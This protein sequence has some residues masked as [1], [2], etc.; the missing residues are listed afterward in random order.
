M[1][2]S[3]KIASLPN[4][5]TLLDDAGG[6]FL[7]Q[8][9]AATTTSYT[10]T[11][12]GAVGG[13]GALLG[14]TNSAGA[15]GWLTAL[16]GLTI[17]N[18]VI[19]GSTPAAITGTTVTATSSFVGDI[20]GDVTGNADTATTLATPRTFSITGDGTSTFAA[21]NGS[22]NVSGALTLATVNSNVGSFGSTTAIPVVTVNAKGLVTAVSTASVSSV[23]TVA[24]DS[25]SND[26]VTLGTDTLTF[27]GTANEIETTVSDNQIQIGLPATILTT[28]QSAGDNSTKVATT[29]YVDTATAALVDSAPSTLDTLNE[30]AA[31]LG[32]D[33]N[34]ATTLTSS[35]AAKLPLAGGTMTGDIELNDDVK[36]SFGTSQDL[37]IYH[38]GT[39]SYITDVGT[40]GLKIVGNNLKILG[41]AATNYEEQATFTDN[42]AVNLTY[43][44][45]LRFATNTSGIYVN[46]RVLATGMES[47]SDKGFTIG[48]H[49]LPTDN[50]TTTD[51][52]VDL[53]SSSYRFRQIHGTELHGTLQ[54]AAQPNITSL[55]TLTGLTVS[56]AI[57]G[58]V[59]GSAATV[60]GSSQTAITSVGTLSSLAI[61]GDLTVDTNTL[62]VDTT[63]NRIGILD[64]SPEVTLDVGA[65]T[66]AVH[67]PVGTTAQRP[68]S[69]AAGYIRYNSDTGGFEGYTDSWGEI[70][71]GG[72]SNTFTKDSF[73]GDGSTTAFALSQTTGSEDNLI[74]FIDGVFQTQSAYSIVTASGTTTLT[75]SVA[76][77]NGTEIIVYSVASA[78]SGANLNLDTMTGD[79][80]TVAMSLSISAVNENNT[81]VYFDGVYQSK[82]NYSISGTTLTF[83]TAPATGVEVEVMTMTQTEINVPVDN[84]VTAAKLTSDSVT[85][86]KILDDNVTAAKLEHSINLVGNPTT[87]TQSASDNSTKIA[88]TAYVETAAAAAAAAVV[89]AAPSTLDTLNELAAALGDDP[90]FATTVTNSIAAK[91]PL[92]NP[93]FTGSF[94]S[95]GIDDNADAIAITIDS[96]E[97]VGIGESSPSTKLHLGGTAP[98]DSIIRQD[99]TASGTNWEIGERTAGKWQIFEDDTDSI[100]AT[101]M[102]SGNVGLGTSSPNTYDSR[103]NNLVVGDSGDAGVTI[104]SGASSNARLV[105]AASG[106]T[107]LANGQIDYDNAN[108]RMAFATAGT[109]R[110]FIDSVGN[111]GIGVVPNAST[112]TYTHFQVARKGSGILSFANSHDIKITGNAYYNSGW[113]YANTEQAAMY[114]QTLGKHTFFYAPSGTA[115]SAL[116]WTTALTIDNSGNV[117]IGTSNPDRELDLVKSGDNC[118][119]SITSGTSN[120]AGIVFGDTDD[121]DQSGVLH[122]NTGNY[123]YFNTSSTEAMRIDSSGNLLVGTNSNPSVGK[124]AIDYAR[125]TSAGMRIKD[126]VGSGGTGVIAD[127]YNSSNTSMGAITHDSSNITYGGTSDYRL[128][129]NVN[130]EFDGL[131]AVAQLKP[132]KFTWINNPNVGVMYGFIAHEVSDVVA[133]AVVGEKDAVNEDGSVQPQMLDQSKLIPFLTK[134]IQEQQTLIESLTDRIAALEK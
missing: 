18:S 126:T 26:T 43:S 41:S 14:T 94:T 82:A 95:P 69:P 118:V 86:D 91:A 87:T 55:G 38:D 70:G 27:A 97:N 64:S 129:E 88:T 78:V 7:A 39:D 93:T 107:G 52:L 35:V 109:D 71:G 50:Q 11:W 61:S 25:G 103:A 90:N 73:S 13:S 4:V 124:I 112:N 132:T 44:G 120:I 116:S 133:Q 53:G 68:S 117:G 89:D 104:F 100:V 5:L 108:D 23:L 46:G 10:V 98:G 131:S 81:Q 51:N 34:F 60:T 17:N 24:A 32:D 130:Y 96:S 3:R 42:G 105:F 12:P 67:M 123:L 20:T 28:T 22:A 74:A 115:D 77:P 2:N 127:F 31:A 101:F 125:G 92:A 59:T 21:F 119:M 57:S 16:S 66:D 99:S 15:M 48:N 36:A 102:S 113:K 106:D 45:T 121:D 83:S 114:E 19:G 72:G 54:T 49:I 65:A 47:S 30:L 1:S 58:S 33:P 76:P 85:T 110:A 134:A 56:S 63:N 8:Q 75:F 122:H 79:G 62:K 84:T 128:K 6:E 9:A 37:Q 29:A 40:G 111:V 80:S